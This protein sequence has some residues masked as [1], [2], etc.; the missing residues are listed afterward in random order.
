MKSTGVLRRIDEL[1]RIV[2]PKE[3]RKNLKIRDG[4]SLEI[5][6]E[7]DNVILK[8]FSMMS[9]MSEIAQLCS[10][11]IHDVINKEII[12]TDRDKVIAASGSLKKKYLDKEISGFLESAISRRDNYVEKY[13]KEIEISEDKKEEYNYALSSIVANG[14]A[15]GVVL[16]LSS[17]EINDIDEKSANFISKFLSKHLE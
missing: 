12:I 15:V 4:E 17:D 5:Y 2:I 14:D 7:S 16:V 8:K 11:S 9:D 13:K 6:V 1:G 10:D 3:I